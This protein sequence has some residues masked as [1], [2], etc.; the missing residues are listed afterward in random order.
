M[1]AWRWRRLRRGV[2]TGGRLRRWLEV[3]ELFDAEWIGRAHEGL[4][5]TPAEHG[6][7]DDDARRQVALHHLDVDL[8]HRA[9]HGGVLHLVHDH[10]AGTAHA[11][12]QAISDHLEHD[13]SV[14]HHVLQRLRP[15]IDR[16]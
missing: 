16:E 5:S 8:H 13:A 3:F 4:E 6:T 1:P 2:W 11:I 7:F 12:D 14:R 9:R 15:A 10:G